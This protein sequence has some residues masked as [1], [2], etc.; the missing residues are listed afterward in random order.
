V[1]DLERRLT[2]TDLQVCFA[3]VRPLGVVDRGQGAS[4]WTRYAVFR[5]AGPRRDLLHQGCR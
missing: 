1:L 2:L 5:V 4:R 3:E